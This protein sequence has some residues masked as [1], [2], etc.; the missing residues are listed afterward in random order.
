MPGAANFVC[1]DISEAES[2]CALRFLGY[3][4]EE[5]VGLAVPGVT[6]GGL[7]RLIEPVIQSFEFHV[8]QNDNFAAF[9]G[10]QRVLHKWGGE[11]LTKHSREHLA[12]DFL[13]LHLYRL[14]PPSQFCHA[15]YS[16]RWQR[17][18]L[19]RSELIAAFVR[20]SFRRTRAKRS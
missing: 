17:E 16:T 1:G 6:G 5:S 19:G 3:E 9:F 12:Y 7:S 10:L 20:D 14:E 18:F 8:D 13:F 11:S 2:V 15:D 4:Y